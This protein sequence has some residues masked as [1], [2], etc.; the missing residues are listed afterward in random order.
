MRPDVPPRGTNTAGRAYRDDGLV[1]AGQDRGRYLAGKQGRFSPPQDKGPR[2][3]FPRKRFRPDTS[4]V[5]WRPAPEGERHTNPLRRI[6]SPRRG[7][8]SGPGPGQRLA[9][10][11][12]GR[13]RLS[14]WGEGIGTPKRPLAQALSAW[15]GGPWGGSE[16]ARHGRGQVPPTGD[17]PA[18]GRTGPAV[19][20][21]P[22]PGAQLRRGAGVATRVPY[23]TRRP[24]APAG[25][26][27]GFGGGLWEGSA[28]P[29]GAPNKSKGCAAPFTAGLRSARQKRRRIGG[30]ALCDRGRA[31]TCRCVRR[32][33][34]QAQGHA[35]DCH[36]PPFRRPWGGP[37]DD[38]SRPEGG[39]DDTPAAARGGPEQEVAHGA[40]GD[41]IPAA[42]DTTIGP[43]HKPG[44]LPPPEGIRE[45]R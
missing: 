12:S 24:I 26:L 45:R 31:V 6:P 44:P 40:A 25:P 30:P 29:Q 13:V 38:G 4:Q 41:G 10:P 42:T 5:R 8:V 7:S 3:P 14:L 11:M 2:R 37:A 18:T 19:K 27:G 21:A 15:G 28:P 33:T 22:E 16:S 1:V 36:T 9:P 35:R 17:P 43:D 34:G 20:A 39:S 32:P 23:K